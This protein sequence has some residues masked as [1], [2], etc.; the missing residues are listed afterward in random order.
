MQVLSVDAMYYS[1][2]NL[3][4]CISNIVESRSF[5]VFAI[6]VLPISLP[7]YDAFSNTVHKHK[8]GPNQFAHSAHSYIDIGPSLSRTNSAS[9]SRT[10]IIPML[11]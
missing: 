2:L 10:W 4:Q 1:I 9:T 5:P 6:D 7:T 3:F 8:F 11:V